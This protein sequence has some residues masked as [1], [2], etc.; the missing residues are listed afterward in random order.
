MDNTEEYV[1]TLLNMGFPNEMEI[2]RAL[3]M[4]KNELNDAITILTSGS[5][6][7]YD[8][9]E[10][11]DIEMKDIQ[12]PVQYSSPPPSYDDVVDPGFIGVCCPYIT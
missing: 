3:R 1:N 6:V 5:P 4:S 11:L 7:N 12:R 10:D 9:F 8:G 2:R